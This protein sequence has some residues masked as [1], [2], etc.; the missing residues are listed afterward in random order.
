M[1]DTLYKKAICGCEVEVQASYNWMDGVVEIDDVYIVKACEYHRP[2]NSP[3]YELENDEL[4][5]DCEDDPRRN[6][7]LTETQGERV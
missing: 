7:K 5:D 2:D 1:T 6:V 4:E 3:E